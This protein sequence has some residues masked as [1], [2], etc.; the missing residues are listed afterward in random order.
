MISISISIEKEESKKKIALNPLPS[1]I[2]LCDPRIIGQGAGGIMYCAQYQDQVVAVKTIRFDCDRKNFSRECNVLRKLSHKHIVK[3]IMDDMASQDDPCLV[4]EYASRFSLEEIVNNQA[5]YPD[6]DFY[7]SRRLAIALDVAYGIQYLHA[8]KPPIIHSDLKS[9]NIL[10]REDWSAAIADFGLCRIHEEKEPVIKNVG[11]I[12]YMAPECFDD[13]KP[14]TP[15]IDIYGLG[16]IL[17]ELWTRK[18]PFLGMRPITI[19]TKVMT[20]FHPEL[21]SDILLSSC[22]KGYSKLMQNCWKSESRKRPSI[23]NVILSLQ[24]MLKSIK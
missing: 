23:D 8:Q 10:V 11:T 24:E 6:T 14:T 16:M 2:K 22:P 13:E 19:I 21:P 17:F 3:Y 9:S 15:A 12:P 7:W 18:E 4:L 1:E 5:K 20:G